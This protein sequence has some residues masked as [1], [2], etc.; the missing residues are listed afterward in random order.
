M[1]RKMGCV[2]GLGRQADLGLIGAVNEPD[3][4]E[5]AQLSGDERQGAFDRSGKYGHDIGETNRHPGNRLCDALQ[6]SNH[7]TAANQ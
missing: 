7:E 6:A 3:L 5:S 4:G 2:D 1:M